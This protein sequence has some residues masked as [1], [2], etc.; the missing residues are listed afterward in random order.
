MRD[1]RTAVVVGLACV[2]A[3][4]C[5]AQSS[6][7][8]TYT[9]STGGSG[10][11]DGGAGTSGGGTAGASGTGGT[12]PDASP[13]AQVNPCEGVTCNTPPPNE[14][15][16]ENQLRVYSTNGTCD[17]GT[18]SY[19]AQLVDCPNGC[20]ANACDGDPC[21]GMSCNTPPANTC[22]DSTHL[23]VYESPGTCSDGVC[24]YDSHNQFCAHGCTSGACE[25]DPCAG[26][27]CNNPP[28]NYCASGTHLAVYETPG[29]CDDG[30]CSYDSHE[31]FCQFGCAGGACE[32]DP[33]IGVT[34]TSPPA[35][36]CA[37]SDTLHQYQSAGSCSE[38][39]CVYPADDISCPHGCESGACLECTIDSDCAGEWCDDGVCKP[40]DSNAHCG[41]SCTNCIATGDVCNATSTA[42]VD[43]NIDGDCASGNWCNA[44]V[45]TSCTTTDHCGVACIACPSTQP[46]CE[47]FQC[48]CTTTSCGPY[49]VCAGG[50]CAFCNTNSACGTN[51]APCQGAT[52]HCLVEGTTSAC[53]ACTNDTHCTSPNICD[54]GT[55]TCMDPCAVPAIACTTGSQNR[56]GWNNARTIGRTQAATTAG[57][58]ISDDTCYASDNFDESSG[59]WDANSD[60]AY[61]IYVRAGERLD[62][63]MDSGWDCPFDYSYWYMTLSIYDTASGCLTTSKGTRVFCRDQDDA[64]SVSWTAPEDG[65]Y[66]VI[67][68]GSS[69]FGD[70]GDYVFQVKL[71]CNQAGCECG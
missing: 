50:S 21:I 37:D 47:G 54:Q 23:E 40:C 6:S 34:C 48:R 4:G 46:N 42:C 14:C 41:P 32:G 27:S 9:E 35:D 52:P 11:Q 33:C 24:Q 16:D 57:Y 45:C 70:E 44:N 58:Q 65:W 19:S 56:N 63:S 1:V 62:I 29:T 8:R 53:V 68:D 30:N 36:Y 7:D 51:C 3:S 5:S 49:N 15:A 10:G 38:G 43:C 18:C 71:T 64:H 25:G 13:D 22:A 69:A 59:C 67:V 60:H 39:N 2:V 66:Y 12:L 26:V 20:T 61:R 31:E 28:A 55:H 17:N